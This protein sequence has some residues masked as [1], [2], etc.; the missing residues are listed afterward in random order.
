VYLV[1]GVGVL[2]IG[3]MSK[4]GKFFGGLELKFNIELI[5]C[6][7]SVIYECDFGGWYIFIGDVE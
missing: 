5:G 6:D 4:D 2:V 1:D 3:F 7:G